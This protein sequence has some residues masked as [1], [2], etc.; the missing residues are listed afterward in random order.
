LATFNILYIASFGKINLGFC[1]YC[2]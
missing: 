1:P 2:I